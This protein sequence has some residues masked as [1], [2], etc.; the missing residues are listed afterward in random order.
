MPLEHEK[1]LYGAVEA[2]G[3]KFNCAVIT[4]ARDIIGTK[5]VA[6]TTPAETLQEVIEFFAPHR[7][8]LLAVGVASFGPIDLDTE[9]STYG[10]ITTTPK[11][12]WHNADVVGT[13][14]RALG[15]PIGWDT[16][17]NGAALAE[18]RWGAAIDCDPTVYITVGTGIGGGAIV[19]G[20]AVHGLMHPEMGH[21]VVKRLPGDEFPG[22]CPYHGDCLEGMICG[23]ALERRNNKPGEEVAA[24]D[25]IWDLVAQYLAGALY[26]IT[27]LLSPKR[28]VIGG[29]VGSRPELLAKVMA[30]LLVLNNHY[31]QP[32]DKAAGLIVAPGLGSQ[33]GV[34][35]AFELARQ[36]AVA[37]QKA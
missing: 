12:G 10:Y 35:G 5:R 32:L 9:S 21:L 13:L 34:M 33:S 22:I 37:R 20:K 27:L 19:N 30:R 7:D 2:G 36:A 4:A 31:V 1:E 16:D 25:P 18:F 6:T 17:V 8:S 23:P 11:P 15:V 26:P 28:I 14:N 3:T 29:G 24:D